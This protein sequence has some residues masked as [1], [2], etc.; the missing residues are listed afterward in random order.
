MFAAELVDVDALAHV[1]LYS[2]LATV[3]L[4]GAYGTL[5]LALDRGDHEQRRPARLLLAVLAGGACVAIVA[6]G[7]WAMTQK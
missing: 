7:L 1:A 6:V 3:G 2:L 4:V 5:I